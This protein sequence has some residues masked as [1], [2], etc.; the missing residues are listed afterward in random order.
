MGDTP[1]HR[2][3]SHARRSD[4]AEDRPG[5][6]PL[7]PAHC[8]E[9][10]NPGF[11]VIQAVVILIE[12]LAGTIE[13]IVVL[14]EFSPGQDRE[15]IQIVAG[16]RVLRRNGFQYLQLVQLFING[17][18]GFKVESQ[19]LKSLLKLLDFRRLA[20]FF[21]AQFLLDG[22]QLFLEKKTLAVG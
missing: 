22:L 11:H 12:H 13:V 14:A 6:V 17:L 7:D 3:L 16:H 9:F 18:L 4:Q 21:Q 1:S 15:P 19:A 8:D 20:L 2:G 5:D 10:Q